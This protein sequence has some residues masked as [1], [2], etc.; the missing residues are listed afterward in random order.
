MRANLKE[1]ESRISNHN[2]VIVIANLAGGNGPAI[3]PMVCELAKRTKATV[4]SIAIMPFGF[5]KEKIF[6][7]GIALKRLRENSDS[8]IIADNDAF[9]EINPGLS[10]SECFAIINKS[11][12]LVIESILSHGATENVSLVCPG[13]QGG[14]ESSMESLVAMAYRNLDETSR[15]SRAIVY[16]ENRNISVG[17]L[18]RLTSFAEGAFAE[19][20]ST[21]IE[22]ANTAATGVDSQIH[23]LASGVQKTRFDGYD[24]LAKIIPAQNVLDWDEPECGI[25]AQLNIFNAE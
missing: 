13:V 4:I 23:L 5:E 14:I 3:A 8:T 16:V 11:V 10:P 15:I 7:S 1:I 25:D 18:S 20:G 12:M 2:T 19:I 9:I 17:A 24:P 22:I 6:G 21:R